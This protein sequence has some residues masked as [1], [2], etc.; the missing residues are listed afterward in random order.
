MFIL[1]LKWNFIILLVGSGFGV[2]EI[3]FVVLFIDFW[4]LKQKEKEGGREVSGGREGVKE[5]EKGM[6]FSD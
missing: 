2:K 1:K 3:L 4:L 5:R 6:K